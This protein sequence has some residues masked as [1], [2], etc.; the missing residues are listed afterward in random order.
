MA[1]SGK[2]SLAQIREVI[3]SAPAI[4]LIAGAIL[5]PPPGLDP[6]LDVLPDEET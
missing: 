1:A 6:P 4:A 5:G 3:R 2:P